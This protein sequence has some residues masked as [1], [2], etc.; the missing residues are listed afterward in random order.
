MNDTATP[1]WYPDEFAVFQHSD[2]DLHFLGIAFGKVQYATD[3]PDGRHFPGDH[4]ISLSLY[5]SGMTKYA[6]IEIESFT[7]YWP[8]WY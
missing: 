3:Y 4:N 7:Q 5:G 8:I 1:H 2:N 6:E